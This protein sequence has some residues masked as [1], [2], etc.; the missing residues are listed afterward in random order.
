MNHELLDLIRATGY[1]SDADHLTSQARFDLLTRSFWRKAEALDYNISALKRLLWR[2]SGRPEEALIRSLPEASIQKAVQTSSKEKDPRKRIKETAAAL[3]LL[4][5]KGEREIGQQ[6][7]SYLVN[8]AQPE[9]L[10]ADTGRIRRRLL[11]NAASWLSEAVPGLY[12][13]G[14]GKAALVGAHDTAARALAIQEYN[15]FKEVDSQISRHVEEVIAEA[16]GRKAKASLAGQPVELS[17]IH[18][19]VVGYKTVDGKELGLADYAAMLAVTAARNF[20]N[21]GSLNNI[22]GR[23][24]DLAL[25]SREI[26]SNSCKV[27]RKWAG[28]IVSIS[29]K[30]KEYPPLEQAV[31]EGL[32]HPHCIHTLL[33]VNYEGST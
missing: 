24:D 25:I 2:M 4:Y 13:M 18:E 27:C 11:A 33:P 9:K 16:E 3:A 23:G 19:K 14:A 26:R 5:K 20:F 29:G 30:S 1:L 31:S 12:L 17:G 32:L 8:P 28:K 10:R 22:L 6:I 7:D 21:E 15:R